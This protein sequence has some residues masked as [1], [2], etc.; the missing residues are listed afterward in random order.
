MEPILTMQ[1]VNRSNS[2]VPVPNVEPMENE[3]ADVVETSTAKPFVNA[4]TVAATLTELKTEHIL[5][6]FIKDNE[7]LI[8]QAEFI[9]ATLSVAMIYSMGK[10]FLNLR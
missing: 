8:S 9:Q 6:V 7:P 5:P 3:V 10:E 4:N 1:T 2:L